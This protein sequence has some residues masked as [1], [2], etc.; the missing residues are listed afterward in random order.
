MYIGYIYLDDKLCY[1]VLRRVPCV[2]LCYAMVLLSIP[3][4]T[5]TDKE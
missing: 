3:G 2:A 5:G 4:H 1:G